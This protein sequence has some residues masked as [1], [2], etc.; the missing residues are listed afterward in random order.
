MYFLFARRR[1]SL[2][3]VGAGRRAANRRETSGSDF[4]PRQ[5]RRPGPEG[6]EEEDAARGLV[7]RDEAARALREALREARP[8]EGR[9]RAPRP[10]AGPQARPARRPDRRPEKA[11]GEIAAKVA[12]NSVNSCLC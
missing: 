4:R 10:Q 6:A 8:P 3:T 7:P 1:P 9:G 2:G 5:Q 11:C 12:L